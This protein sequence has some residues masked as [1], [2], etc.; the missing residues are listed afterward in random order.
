M[1]YYT[2]GS[3]RELSCVRPQ[4]LRYGRGQSGLLEPTVIA[5]GDE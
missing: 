2:S 1:A 4:A 3:R 5:L